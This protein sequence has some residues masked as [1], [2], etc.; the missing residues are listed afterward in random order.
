M[1]GGEAD[2]W[3]QVAAVAGGELVEGLGAD[4]VAPEWLGGDDVIQG[5][6]GLFH[7]GTDRGRLIAHL[8]NRK[9]SSQ[10]GRFDRDVCGD[11]FEGKLK[12]HL[13]FTL[14]RTHIKETRNICVPT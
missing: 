11:A 10:S 7:W 8:E 3:R 4:V 14:R 12:M 13:M 2:L 1:C 9:N 6:E 5:R